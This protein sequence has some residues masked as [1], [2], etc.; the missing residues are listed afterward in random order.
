ML[1]RSLKAA[2]EFY[3]EGLETFVPSPDTYDLIWCQWCLLYLTDGAVIRLL[4]GSL[5]LF[6]CADSHGTIF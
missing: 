2:G 6:P 3:N 5:V 4:F 1:R